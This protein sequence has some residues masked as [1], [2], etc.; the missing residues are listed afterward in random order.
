MKG[1]CLGIHADFVCV[2]VCAFVFGS[3]CRC[4]FGSCCRCG[5]GSEIVN[6]FR[7]ILQPKKI[8]VTAV[9]ALAK[10]YENDEE[11]FNREYE[12]FASRVEKELNIP[13][14]VCSPKLCGIVTRCDQ[15]IMRFYLEGALCVCVCVW[16]WGGV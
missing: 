5:F 3:C 7:E 9:A 13:Y 6:C 2:S 15:K 16:I 10:R 8:A 12:E 1:V 4:G 11:T 14:T